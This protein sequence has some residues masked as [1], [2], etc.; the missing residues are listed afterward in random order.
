MTTDISKAP[1]ILTLHVTTNTE[2]VDVSLEIPRQTLLLQNV[3]VEMAS[4]ANALSEKIIYIS[5]PKSLPYIYCVAQLQNR[6][7]TTAK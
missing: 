1:G 2:V 3:R 5:L 4:A 6:R 7:K